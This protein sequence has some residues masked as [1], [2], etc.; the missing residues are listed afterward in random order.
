MNKINFDELHYPTNIEEIL[1]KDV[2]MKMVT[3]IKNINNDYLD[4][5]SQKLFGIEITYRELFDNIEKYAKSLKGYGIEKGDYVTLAMPNIPETIYYIYACNLIG[6]IAY[7]IDPRSTFK[8]MVNC[9]NNSKSK[10]FVCEMGTYYSKVAQNL[11]KLPVE[12]VVVVSPLNILDD[13]KASNSKIQMAGYLMNLKRF[14]EDFRLTFNDNS[15]KYTQKEFLKW[16]KNY[17]GN[18]ESEYDPDIPA[19]V[20]N[21]SGTTGTKV[22]GAV[23]TNRTYN[24]YANEAQF[25]TDQLIR[26]NTYY[27][28][29]PYFS[30]YGSGVG[31][32]VALSYGIVIDNVPKFNGKKSLEDIINDKSNILIG[33]PSLM[34]KLTEMYKEGNISASHVKQYI[35]GGDNV[36]P[37]TLKYENEVLESLGMK[38]KLVYGYGATECM[39]VSTTSPEEFS[40]VYG[41]SGMIYPMTKIKIINPETLEELPY[42]EEGEIYVH[43]ETIMKGYINDEEE[44]K[45]VLKSFDG[46]IYYKTGDKGYVVPTGHLY[47]TGRYKRMMKR[48]DGHQVS[49]IPI[50]NAITKSEYVK[51]CAVVGIKRRK[52]LPG[53]VPTAFIELND[54]KNKE[55][56][57]DIIKVIAEDSLQDLSG[58]RESALAYSVISKIPMTINGKVDFNMLQKNN[59]EDLDF[60][61]LDDLVTRDYFEGLDVDFIRI[62]KGKIKSLNR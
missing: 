35:I 33:T 7:P 12:N 19:I 42:N 48:P 18:Y 40:Y 53:V 25:V 54:V 5:V 10:L 14:Y 34:E 36:S 21:T 4:T 2:D 16:G 22:K 17:I 43:N 27:G 58:E 29:V 38:R 51:N 11:R 61:V 28:Y 20:V 59:F 26:G 8:N 41:S 9:I 24:L 3:H 57:R 31:M 56:I 49:P 15:K 44:T 13:K 1:N 47:L 37:E 6:A 39:P 46:E 62:N 50:E 45:E 23:H 30:M 52:E 32:H 55:N 60:Y